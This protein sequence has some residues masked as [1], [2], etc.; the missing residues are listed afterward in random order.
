MKPDRPLSLLLAAITLSA[1]IL[2]AAPPPRP[3]LLPDSAI[4]ARLPVAFEPNVGQA[5]QGV[6]FVSR[7]SG[8]ALSLH[9]GSLTLNLPATA[10]GSPGPAPTPESTRLRI[11]LAGTAQPGIPSPG[12]RLP[13]VVHDLRG[14][15]PANWHSD[16]PTFDS[17]HY[18]QVFP[19]VD[20]AYHGSSTMAG[21][22]PTRS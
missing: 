15:D 17:V 7:A 11:A 14:N 10:A 20:L 8:F 21:I 22:R 16:I 6:E 9:G 5:P 2:T 12:N 4:H 19:G 1:P 18:S 13:G 3:E